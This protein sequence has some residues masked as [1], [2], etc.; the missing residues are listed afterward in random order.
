MLPLV[1]SAAA[2]ND[3]VPL[4]EAIRSLFRF[5]LRATGAADGVLFVRSYDAD[6]APA[7]VCRVYDAA[8]QRLD[9]ALVPFARSVAASAVSMQ[10][11]CAM[12][13][14]DEA[15]DAGKIELQP[16]ET[17]RHSLLA[18]A[19]PVSPGITV[20]LELFDKR[21]DAGQAIPFTADDHRRL[22]A[23]AEFGTELLRHALAERQTHRVLLDAVAAALGASNSVAETLRGS[24]SERLEQ[25][26]PAA[27]LDQMQASLKATPGMP[28]D[29]EETLRLAEAVRVLALRHGPPAVRHCIGLVESLRQLLDTV[30]GA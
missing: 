21:G 3:P 15:A 27:V 11:P 5:L 10:Q 19:L 30:S 26:P 6:R 20:V 1:Q 4:P 25:P 2:L 8:G 14:L 29:A 13:R 23:A 18:T 24:A 17:D 16:F 22:A 12:D 7:E 9:V 28:V